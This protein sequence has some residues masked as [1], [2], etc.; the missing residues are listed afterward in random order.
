MS[1]GRAGAGRPDRLWFWMLIG[2]M[3]TFIGLHSASWFIMRVLVGVS[4]RDR[5]VEKDM[6]GNGHR[7]QIVSN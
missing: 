2:A 4:Q 6:R 1:S 3:S 7:P 5:L